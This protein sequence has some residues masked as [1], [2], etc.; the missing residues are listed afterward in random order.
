MKY[1]YNGLHMPVIRKVIAILLTVIAG[2]SLFLLLYVG[3]NVRLDGREVYRVEPTGQY[4]MTKTVGSNWVIIP[5]RP[6]DV[7][8]VVSVE[9]TPVYEKF[10]N[11]EVDFVTGSPVVI[12]RDCLRTDLP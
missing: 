3:V 1:N 5:L 9:I 4:R 8:K 10:R 6:E 2:I 12:Y 7:G 11:R